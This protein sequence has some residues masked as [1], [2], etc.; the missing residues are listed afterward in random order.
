[1]KARRPSFKWNRY[2]ACTTCG[3]A[4]A[5]PC[6]NL[7]SLRAASRYRTPNEA[8]HAGRIRAKS[9]QTPPPPP[10]V[11]R[12]PLPPCPAKHPAYGV[13]CSRKSHAG[14]GGHVHYSGVFSILHW[15]DAG[16]TTRL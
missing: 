12:P 1:M 2:P 3:A 4:P 8:P 14:R 11:S 13:F 7:K 16:H 9:D 10:P 5:A 15:D 6:L